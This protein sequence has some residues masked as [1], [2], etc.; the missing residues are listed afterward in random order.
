MTDDEANAR[1]R[2]D[3]YLDERDFVDSTDELNEESDWF[4]MNGRLVLTINL[5]ANA[6]HDMLSVGLVGQRE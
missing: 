3:G 5:D 6:G 4:E 1:V 2:V